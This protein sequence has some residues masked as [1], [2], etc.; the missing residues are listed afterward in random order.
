M[1]K[2]NRTWK[3]KKKNEQGEKKRVIRYMKLRKK[4]VRWKGKK[5]KKGGWK[6]KGGDGKNCYV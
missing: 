5:T 4:N 2:L 3:K 6:R 1:Y